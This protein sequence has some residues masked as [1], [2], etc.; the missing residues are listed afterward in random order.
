VVLGDV[1]VGKSNIIRRILGEEF[2]ELEATI[3]VEFGYYNVPDIDPDDPNI[4][5][6]IQ[7]WDT[8]II[9]IF[10]KKLEQRDIEL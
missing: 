8:C 4:N 10:Y 5:L 2:Q 1:N 3:G 7:I 6:N 9:Y